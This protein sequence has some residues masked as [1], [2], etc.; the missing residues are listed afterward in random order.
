MKFQARHWLIIL[1]LSVVGLSNI[2][3]NVSPEKT[4]G[5]TGTL[6][7]YIT[8]KPFPFDMIEEAIVTITKIEVRRS[9]NDDD[10]GSETTCTTDEECNDGAYCN[11]EE[12]CL[13]EVCIA[14]TPPCNPDD[15]CIE[16]EQTCFAVSTDTEEEEDDDDSGDTGRPFIEIF[17]G[18]KD[19]NLIDLQNGSTD[20]LAEADLP[21]G[22]Y[23]QMRIFVSE[24]RIVLKEDAGEFDLTV[25]SGAQTGIKLHFE[26]E[27][28]GD[29]SNLLLDFDLSRAFKPIPGGA[30]NTPSDIRE[31]KFSPSLAMRLSDLDETGSISGTV[32]TDEAGEMS[33]LNDVTVTVFLDGDEVTSTSTEA[34]GHY[35]FIGL[36][37]GDYRVDF[38]LTDFNDASI[39]N[40]TVEA[41]VATEDIDVVMTPVE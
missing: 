5:Q 14:G 11:G 27:L 24:G 25:P 8:D 35:M 18:E 23:T 37:P 32:T 12:T 29:G 40:I 26:F 3:C 41:G 34:D 7:V 38:S 33:P 6:R 1:M 30:I 16:D 21:V 15:L 19:F 9:D 17:S 31:F 39:N 20:L 2:Q 22:T 28:G 36:V 4:S 13:D 10:D